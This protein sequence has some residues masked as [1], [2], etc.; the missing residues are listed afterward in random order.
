ML[1]L[2]VLIVDDERAICYLIRKLIHWEELG[3]IYAGSASDGWEA[4]SM[5]QKKRPDIIITDIQMPKMNGMEL[6][7]RFR[8]EKIPTDFVIVSGYQEF[9]YAKQAIRF[10]VEDYLLKPIKEAELNRIL[11]RI[12]EKSQENLEI[13]QLKQEQQ[14][15]ERIVSWSRFFA[16]NRPERTRRRIFVFVGIIFYWRSFS[17]AFPAREKAMQRQNCCWNDCGTAM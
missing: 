1:M 14:R 8:E 2:S 5:A 17:F 13:V 12:C 6:I 10:G 3:L 16:E 9:E 4:W 15:E 11:K 7:E